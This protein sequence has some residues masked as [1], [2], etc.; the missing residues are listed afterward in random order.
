[1]LSQST[2]KWAQLVERVHGEQSGVNTYNV[3][4]LWMWSNQKMKF[5]TFT[6]NDDVECFHVVVQGTHKLLMMGCINLKDHVLIKIRRANEKM[7]V[8]R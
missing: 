2:N 4:R 5:S 6:R 8:T 7:N 1:V 3:R